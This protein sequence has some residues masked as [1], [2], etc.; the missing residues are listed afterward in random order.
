[1]LE[2]FHICLK[3]VNIFLKMM[4]LSLDMEDSKRTIM[5]RLKSRPVFAAHIIS[6][7]LEV[8][9]EVGWLFNALVTK[10]SFIEITYFLPC[11]IFSTVS[12]FKYIS[13]L[14]YSHA[15][16]DLIKAIEK[17]QS[18]VVQSDKERDLFEKKL[19]NDFVTM[20]LNISNRTVCLIIMGLMMFASIS[21]FI[22]IP[23]YYKTGELKLEL[24]FLGHYPFNE[25]DMRVYP[26]IYFHQIFAAAEAV[27]MVYAPDSFFFACCT[28]THIQFMLLQYD[29]ERIV[30][31]N[32]PTYD[33]VKFKKLALRHIELMKCVNMMEDIFSK[34]LLFNSMTSSIIMCL[35]GFT[36]MVIM[37]SFSAFLIFGLMQ[38]FLY[39]YYGDSIM[40]SSME[41]SDAI[42]NSLWYKISASERKDVCIVLMRA[43]KPCQVTAYGFFDINLRAFTSILSTSWS[44]F[45]L[46]KTM[47]N[48]DDVTYNV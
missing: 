33:K 34:S 28:F 19:A 47:Y 17:V 18:R 2:H 38:I 5:Q 11:L 22:I 35:N 21:L 27:F 32:S 10:K 3:R 4:G 12:N 8:A 29:I 41:V 36:V 26:L 23:R 7:N 16:N 46:L 14:Y 25:F 20:F 9:A 42:Y 24:P 44:Y 1:M 31:E 13:F 40:R 39:C 45:A 37:A 43:Q 15:I 30:P 6:F 48:P